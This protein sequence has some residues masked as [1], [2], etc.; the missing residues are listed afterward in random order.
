MEVEL[1]FEVEV[2]DGVETNES[3]TLCVTLWVVCDGDS[4]GGDSLK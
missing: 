3:V 4:N 1:L 2:E